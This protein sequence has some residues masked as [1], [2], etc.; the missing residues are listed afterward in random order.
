MGEEVCACPYLIFVTNITNE[1]CGEKFVMW[2]I[3]RFFCMTNVEKSEISPHVEYFKKSP[4]DRCGKKL[5]F[6]HMLSNF[7]FHYLTDVEKSEVFPHLARVRCGDCLYICTCYAIL[8]KIWFCHDLRCFVAKSVLS[9]FTQFCVEK[10]WT[11]DCASGEKW[12]IWGMCVSVWCVWGPSSLGAKQASVY[13]QLSTPSQAT[14]IHSAS[15]PSLPL[16]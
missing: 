12:Q 16:W 7:K 3:F 6:L 15:S 5:T 13:P 14:S 2:R 1:I 9:R 8:L 11:K 10:N 4:H